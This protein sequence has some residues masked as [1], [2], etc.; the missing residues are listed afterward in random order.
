MSLK[1]LIDTHALIWF[2]EDDSRL[3][4]RARDAI[5]PR[6]NAIL[7]S[8]ASVW[9]IAIKVSAGRLGFSE[10]PLI[11]GEREGLEPLP[12][13]MEHAWANRDLPFRKD[14]KD[15]FD[16]MIAAQ[17]LC[18]GIPVISSDPAFDG[19]GVERIW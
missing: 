15:P 16:R 17:A 13:S 18:E 9:E 12:V 5:A 4:P 11:A 19:Y 7:V 1:A 6:A 8:A 14:H 10:D 2:L 3:S